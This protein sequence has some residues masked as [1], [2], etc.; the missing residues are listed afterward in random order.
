[1]DEAKEQ[2]RKVVQ[3]HLSP[4]KYTRYKIARNGILLYGPRGTGKT[5]L[6]RATAGEF[7]LNFAYVSAPPLLNRWTGATGENIQAVFAQATARKPV[8]FFLDEIDALGLG[9]QDEVPLERGF[10]VELMKWQELC[11]ESEGQWLFPS[12]VTGRPLHVDSI[13]TDHLI[14]TSLELGLG[15]IGFHTFRHSCRAWLDETGAP[16]GVQQKLMRHAHISTTMNPHGNA[17]WKPSAKPI[18]LWC[19][20][21]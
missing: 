9:R 5:F 18:G 13:R 11:L 4:E 17:Q 7:I 15:R 14:P 19:R 3:A 1:M 21:S 20:D 10:I 6:A 8:L 16:V 2:I 12:P